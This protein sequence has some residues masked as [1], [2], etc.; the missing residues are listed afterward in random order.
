[1]KR[2][3]FYILL[4]LVAVPSFADTFVAVVETV[5]ENNAIGRSERIFL[6]DKLRECA[7]KSLPADKG[8]V[9]MTRE[10]I[11]QMLPPGKKI[12]DCEGEC[13][14]ETGKN[15]NADYIAQA[16]VGKF[17]ESLTLT[18][19]L[20]ETAKNNLVGSFTARKPNA[21]GL[22]DDLENQAGGMF[23]LIAGNVLM[24]DAKKS[25]VKKPEAKKP[26]S[27][28]SFVDPRDNQKYEAVKIGNQTW[29]AQN[30]NYEI[31]WNES[32]KSWCYGDD[33]RSCKKTGR[34]YN[35]KA[36]KKACP[37]GWHLPSV[38]EMRALVDFAGGVK[39]AGKKLKSGTAWNGTDDF[40]FSVLPAGIRNTDGTFGS[41]GVFAFFWTSVESES[42]VAFYIG[43]PDGADVRL[44]RN[45][46]DNGF[47]VRCV[48]D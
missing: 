45:Y 2:I 18:V 14:V 12:E 27:K 7:K 42:D 3:L 48:K 26:V 28:T 21:E 39:A 31:R 44:Q 17:G 25:E 1:M 16:R 6:T 38:E 24:P 37:A 40:G 32:G 13:L 22:L 46:K 5:A 47:S 36:A 43:F 9:I 8:Y 10:N 23:A 29:M 20:Y 30:L 11:M 4:L 19:E 41:I 33:D 34:L 35:W 15:I